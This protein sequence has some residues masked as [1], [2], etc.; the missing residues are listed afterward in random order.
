MGSADDHGLP[1]PQSV[2]PSPVSLVVGIGASAGGIQA[3]TEFFHNAPVEAP[4]AYVVILHLSPDHESRLAEVL[5]RST[6]MPVTQVREPLP[7][8][9][10]HVYVIPPSASL[11]VSDRRLLLAPALRSDERK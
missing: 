11:R 8:E 2:L 3:L 5:Q 10:G 7:L 6:A 9:P 1:E 4:I